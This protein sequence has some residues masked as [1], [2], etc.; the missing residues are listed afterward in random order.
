VSFLLVLLLSVGIFY[1]Y[2]T[3][4]FYPR[5]SRVSFDA[6]LYTCFISGTLFLSSWLMKGDFYETDKI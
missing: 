2:G 3:F 1:Q 5:V 6:L 4:S